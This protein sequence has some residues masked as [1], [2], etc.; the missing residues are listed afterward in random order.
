M[1]PKVQGHRLT[2]HYDI[3]YDATGHDSR[4]CCTEPERAVYCVLDVTLC[5]STL[6][7]VR[8]MHTKAGY[9][10]GW[11]AVAVWSGATSSGCVVG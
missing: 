1:L 7:I 9:S 8:E 11:G 10:D 3:V 6:C 5:P 2:D 4:N